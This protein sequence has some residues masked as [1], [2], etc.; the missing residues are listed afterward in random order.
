MSQ[1]TKVLAIDTQRRVAIEGTTGAH[2]LDLQAAAKSALH[3]FVYENISPSSSIFKVY[4]LAVI[5]VGDGSLFVVDAVSNDAANKSHLFPVYRGNLFR[6]YLDLS[7]PIKVGETLRPFIFSNEDDIRAIPIGPIAGIMILS[8][9]EHIM[10]SV[11][12]E[13]P[14][15]IEILRNIVSKMPK[16]PVITFTIDD[17]RAQKS[18]IESEDVFHR[19]K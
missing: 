17:A 16:D 14:I 7:Q 5:K 10:G 1:N 13:G 9:K 4:A 3:R 6:G 11:H 12:E 19:A 15:S 2:K 18:E 8:G